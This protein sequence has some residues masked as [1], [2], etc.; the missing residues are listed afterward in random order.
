MTKK[1]PVYYGWILVVTLAITQTVSWGI[2]YYA[3]TVFIVP[4]ERELGWTRAELSGAFS[5]AL[6]VE[7]VSGLFVGRWLDK[8]GSRSLMTVGSILAALLVLAWA[9]VNNLTVFYLIWFGIGLVMP[10][11]LYAPAFAVV[12]VWF[13][14]KRGRALTVLTFIAGFA[15]VIF[16]PLTD[17]LVS[18]FG[19]RTA[20]MIMASLLAGITVPLHAIVLR[21]RPE[22]LG[23]LPDGEPPKTLDL[24]SPIIEEKIF[25]TRQAMQSRVFW[26][27]T[28]SFTLNTLVVVVISVHLVPYLQDLK[29][30]SGFAASAVGL[31]GVMALPGRLVFNI[32]AERFSRSILTAIIF[33]SQTVSLVILLLV[34]NMV[35]VWLFVALYG[36]GFGAITPMRAGLIAEL[37]GRKFY[38]SISAAINLFMTVAKA[39]GPLGIGIVHDITGNYT[40]VIWFLVIVS[41][42]STFTI[43]LTERS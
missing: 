32:L 35:G 16:L 6:V 14:K 40:P 11:V 28:F 22:D 2:I 8:H 21:R 34:P 4:M 7:G 3:F 26:W 10:A 19:W 9:N 30:D 41:A 25:T 42:I 1:Q 29:Y 18:S 13:N 5:L 27:L 20:L 37:Y 17:W 15:S 31:I 23:L 39:G 38:A 24:N 12:A 36:A 43:L 33:A